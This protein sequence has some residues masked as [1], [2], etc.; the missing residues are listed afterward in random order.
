[1]LHYKKTYINKIL[2]CN[3]VTPIT[4]PHMRML[5]VVNEGRC[6][7]TKW[8]HSASVHAGKKHYVKKMDVG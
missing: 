6:I 5:L 4:F 1:L 7:S 3:T 8:R 2:E